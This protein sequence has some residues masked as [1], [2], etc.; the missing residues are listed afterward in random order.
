ML[1]TC[2][3]DVFG[4]LCRLFGQDVG[5]AKTKLG[6]SINEWRGDVFNQKCTYPPD[7]KV[8]IFLVFICTIQNG[9]HNFR[10]APYSAT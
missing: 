10:T 8:S 5:V 9:P 7:S 2:E 1:S 3:P 6:R 4:L